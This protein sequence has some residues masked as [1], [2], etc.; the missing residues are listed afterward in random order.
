M[1]CPSNNTAVITS[2]IDQGRHVHGNEGRHLRQRYPRERDGGEEYRARDQHEHDG[3]SDLSPAGRFR[4]QERAAPV[5]HRGRIKPDFWRFGISSVGGPLQ[6]WRLWRDLHRRADALSK[7]SV[8]GFFLVNGPR[9][10]ANLGF[11]RL[12]TVEDSRQVLKSG[13]RLSRASVNAKDLPANHAADRHGLTVQDCI[14]RAGVT[15]AA[16]ARKFVSSEVSSFDGEQPHAL[17][18]Q[19]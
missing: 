14:P 15:T 13:S 1:N 6:P 9:R 3:G 10:P 16:N 17:C 12:P 4:C 18:D 2:Q 8:M 5:D 19:R 11:P 7:V